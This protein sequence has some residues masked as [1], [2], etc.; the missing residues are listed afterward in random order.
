M[1]WPQINQFHVSRFPSSFLNTCARTK[2]APKQRGACSRRRRK[3]RAT[4]LSI[5]YLLGQYERCRRQKLNARRARF[6]FRISVFGQRL[7]VDRGGA[8]GGSACHGFFFRER[9]ERSGWLVGPR[10]IPFRPR[11]HLLVVCTESPCV[12]YICLCTKLYILDITCMRVSGCCES[13]PPYLRSFI[14]CRGQAWRL[15]FHS[16]RCV[17]STYS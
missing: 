15:E 11:R 9:E 17:Y 6:L 13:L 5:Y 16:R 1:F 4:L 14:T 7:A 12:P 2:T 8:R 10:W 3:K